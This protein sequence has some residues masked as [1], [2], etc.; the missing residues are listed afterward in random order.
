MLFRSRSWVPSRS[1]GNAR[2]RRVR[3]R[4]WG[5]R[6]S[7]AA[8]TRESARYGGDTSCIEVRLDDDTLIVL[9]AGTGARG[10]GRA[11]ASRSAQRIH[12][13]LTHLHVDHIEGLGAFAPIWQPET[14]LHIWGP[15]S[16]VVSIA[17]APVNST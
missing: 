3:I 7:I 13:L 5:S 9:D 12:L 8:P 16:P 1:S 2:C 11:L 6:G 15:A 4:I 10:L 14:D 17:S